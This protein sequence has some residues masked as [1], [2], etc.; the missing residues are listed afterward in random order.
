MVR[1]SQCR[2]LSKKLKLLYRRVF[3]IMKVIQAK[4]LD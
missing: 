3:A 2:N 4:I 1:N